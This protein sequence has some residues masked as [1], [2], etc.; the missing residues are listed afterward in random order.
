MSVRIQDTEH[1]NQIKDDMQR[2]IPIY[3]N[4]LKRI[5]CTIIKFLDNQYEINNVND[6]PFHI[7]KC[8]ADNIECDENREEITQI[9]HMINNIASNHH[10]GSNFIKKIKKIIQCFKSVIMS[11]LSNY[12]IFSIFKENKLIL[13]YLIDSEIINVS[14]EICKEII[15]KIE[16]NGT[17]YCHFFYPEIK[18]FIDDDKIKEIEKEL[19]SENPNIF[20]NFESKLLEGENDSYICSL[21]RQDSIEEFVSYV[22]RLNMP[23]TSEIKHSIFETNS[24]LIENESTSLIEYSAFFGSIQIFNYL[25][26]MNVELK[27]SIWLY[28]IHSQNTELFHLLESRLL[29]HY[30]F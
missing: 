11:S 7:L 20:D 23:L 9:L 18:K 14:E 13:K 15:Y 2:I 12:E 25:R 22:N 28:A 24:F 1:N 21:I 27:P 19:L 6:E 3:I 16:L 10:R 8:Y 26:M 30:F 4:K 5:Y 17:K 29:R